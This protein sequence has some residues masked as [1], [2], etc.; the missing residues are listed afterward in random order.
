MRLISDSISNFFEV[1]FVA[2]NTSSVSVF[3]VTVSAV[4]FLT[5]VLSV[6]TGFEFSIEEV[7]PDASICSG[8]IFLEAAGSSLY[9]FTDWDDLTIPSSVTILFSLSVNLSSTKTIAEFDC[10]Y[11]LVQGKMGFG[12]NKSNIISNLLS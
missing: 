1:L 12:K 3:S 6:F 5:P 11:C 2:A 10:V 7:S 9:C 4:A 8:I